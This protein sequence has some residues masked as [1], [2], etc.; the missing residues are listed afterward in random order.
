MPS[1]AEVRF[2]LQT[3]FPVGRLA[4]GAAAGV[5]PAARS[6]PEAHLDQGRLHQPTAEGSG[7]EVPDAALHH[8]A[9]EEETGRNAGSHRLTG[10]R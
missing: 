6:T 1:A 3:P 7:E 4:S 9:G 8:Q 5:G 10:E 2:L